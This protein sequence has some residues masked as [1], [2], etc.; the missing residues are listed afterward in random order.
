[1]G[2]DR[3][4]VIVLGAHTDHPADLKGLGEF[5]EVTYGTKPLSSTRPDLVIWVVPD[6]DN[7]DGLEDLA[8]R[9]PTIVL[10]SE[11]RMIDMVDRGCRGFLTWSATAEDIMDA[12]L[13]VLDGGAVVP[14]EML[15]TLLRHV[16]QR[17][18]D[19]TTRSSILDE[20]TDR[21]R[22]VYELAVQGARKEEIGDKLFISPAT[23]RTHLQ[24]VYRKLGVHSQTEL[25]SLNGRIAPSGETS[26]IGEQA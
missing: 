20:L 13:T 18:R 23:A 1:V 19:S 11:R 14:P 4:R 2:M 17:R 7:A 25:M 6:D 22:Q 10:A 16:V 9:T 12:A 5:G 21:E 15:G 24:R 3:K 8:S 26:E